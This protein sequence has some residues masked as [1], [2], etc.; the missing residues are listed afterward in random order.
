MKGIA[1]TG[2]VPKLD[3]MF[4]KPEMDFLRNFVQAQMVAYEAAETGTSDGW[5]YWTAKMEGSAFAEWDFLRGVREGWIPVL[6]DVHQPSQDL[7]GTCYD[8]LFKTSDDREQVVHTFPDPADLPEVRWRGVPIDDDVVLSHGQLLMEPD[9]IHHRQRYND[10]GDATV[11]GAS[12]PRHAF[13]WILL[14]ALAAGLVHVVRKHIKRR[15]KQAMYT[16]LQH[17]PSTVEV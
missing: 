9:G 6:A 7:Y 11:A 4:T 3:K 15:R 12:S 14:M 1:A 10:D 5:F 2:V 13:Q 8:I 17:E 16:S